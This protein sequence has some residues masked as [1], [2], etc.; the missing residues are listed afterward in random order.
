MKFRLANKWSSDPQLS[1]PA[2]LFSKDFL[3]D[4]EM[5]NLSTA[6]REEPPGS[7]LRRRAGG[8][9]ALLTSW[10]SVVGEGARGGHHLWLNPEGRAWGRRRSSCKWGGGSLASLFLLAAL[11]QDD[12]VPS[13]FR[14]RKC[15]RRARQ[16]RTPE[17]SATHFILGPALLLHSSGTLA[18]PRPES[19][20]PGRAWQ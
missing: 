18:S 20:I 19:L 14:G 4:Q 10:S 2:V 16:D 11:G 1:W 7:H 9:S 6:T 15:P 12:L 13:L 3:Q 8:S 5:A 17:E